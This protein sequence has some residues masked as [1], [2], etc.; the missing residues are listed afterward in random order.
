LRPCAW[1]ITPLKRLEALPEKARPVTSWPS[2]DEAYTDIAHK[3]GS[4][5]ESRQEVLATASQQEERQRD[6]E[7]AAEAAAHLFHKKQWVEAQ[8]AFAS[9]LQLHQ[10]GFSPDKSMLQ[11]RISACIAELQKETEAADFQTRR[12]EY[13]SLL[14]A[15]DYTADPKQ[16][17]QMLQKAMQ[18]Y[19][20][21]FPGSVEDLR[22]R[23]HAAQTY[24]QNT[25]VSEPDTPREKASVNVKLIVLAAMTIVLLVLGVNFLR[26]AGNNKPRENKEPANMQQPEKPATEH[27]DWKSDKTIPGLKDWLDK[28]PNADA[29]E[30]AAANTHLQSLLKKRENDLKDARVYLK[31]KDYP[32]VEKIIDTIL[33]ENPKD[34]EARRLRGLIPKY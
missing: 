27:L 13:E 31:A 21:G 19:E 8:K 14:A 15:V 3:I 11:S 28:N 9:A 18:Q 26:S 5:V 12:K 1:T 23:L 22:Q 34:E 25:P 30:R 20:P 16:Q 33:R 17:A 10:P 7:A 2:Q 29:Q 4:I 32:E 6:F 24:R